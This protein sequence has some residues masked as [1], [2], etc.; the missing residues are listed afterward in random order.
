MPNDALIIVDVQRDF[1]DPRMGSLYVPD[2]E[3]VVPVINGMILLAREL[4]WFIVYTQDWHPAHTP[5][6]QQDGGTWPVH[7]VGG[8]P[9]AE[10]DPKLIKPR[11]NV[12]Y[13]LRKGEAWDGYSAFQVVNPETKLSRST[14]LDR[15]LH[16]KGVSR[17]VVVGL[18][19]DYCVK[20][21]GI[22][23]VI[24]G[25]DTTVFLDATRAVNSIKAD[26]AGAVQQMKESGV[27]VR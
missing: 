25:F 5:H 16:G 26:Y 9:G 3:C 21:T 24:A 12:D 8:T 1:A 15:I 27:R 10:L 7:C 13:V 18:A 14:G 11:D 17:V 6:F 22:D 23:S 4:S 20:E 19:L 2:G